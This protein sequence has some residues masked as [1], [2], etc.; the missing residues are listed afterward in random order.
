MS[1]TRRQLSSGY[2]CT[3]AVEPVMPAE[4][5]RM[6]IFPSAALAALAAAATASWSET[7]RATV[8]AAPTSVAAS[9]KAAAS[10]SHSETWP[11][12]ATMRAATARPRPEAPPVITAVRPAKRPR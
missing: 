11:P 6:S 12:S 3:G 5:T 7:S 10:R 2:S 8:W 1:I 9:F 4:A